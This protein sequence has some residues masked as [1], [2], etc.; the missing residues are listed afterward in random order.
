MT[1]FQWLPCKVVARHLTPDRFF[2]PNLSLIRYHP[3]QSHAAQPIPWDRLE[4][5][6]KSLT[7]WINEGVHPAVTAAR[8][9]RVLGVPK[10]TGSQE[11]PPPRSS[12][13][14]DFGVSPRQERRARGSEPTASVLRSPGGVLTRPPGAPGPPT[15]MAWCPRGASP[16]KHWRVGGG[17]AEHAA[18][19]SRADDRGKP[20]LRGRR[21]DAGEKR[22]ALG[23]P[24]GVVLSP[25]LQSP[26]RT[27]LGAPA[28]LQVSHPWG[29]PVTQSS[30]S[31]KH[32]SPLSHVPS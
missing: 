8:L 32:G 7:K 9:A 20:G 14:R 22:G 21:V 3:I 18:R 16:L 1:N 15:P 5:N 24:E 27:Q 23:S 10:D 6:G 13:R 12:G 28:R 2:S 26:H 25:T 17:L 29:W 31:G 11:A 19:G 4:R 30:L